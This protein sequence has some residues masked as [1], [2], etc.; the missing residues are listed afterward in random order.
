MIAYGHK[1]GGYW[2]PCQEEL[3]L[4]GG[5]EKLISKKVMGKL[6]NLLQ[7]EHTAIIKGHI[8]AT[9]KKQAWADLCQAQTSFS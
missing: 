3:T 8:A 5:V 2:C 9:T 4:G 1:Y 6:E 7:L